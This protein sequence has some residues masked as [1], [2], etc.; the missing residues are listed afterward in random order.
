[1]TTKTTP[2]LEIDL[3][4]LTH[5][6]R[7]LCDQSHGAVGA[8]VKA[9]AYGLG[10]EPVAQT[11]CRAG[12][13]TFFVA[14]TREGVALRRVCPGAEIYVL[15][16]TVAADVEDL[17]AHELKPC[18]YS[19]E[20]YAVMAEAC[21]GGRCHVALHVETGINRLGLTE[22]EFHRVVE[23]PASTL[24]VDLIMSHLA[25]SDDPASEYN[26]Q[27]KNRFMAFREL[28]PNVK[29]SL[30][31]S[32]GVFLDQSFHFDLV[33]PGIALYGADPHYSLL[34]RPRLQPV[35]SLISEVAQT[36]IVEPGEGIGYGATVVVE[37]ATEIAVVMGGYADGINRLLGEP[38]QD[39]DFLVQVAGLPAPLLG[40]V[41]MDSCTLD[42]SST[43]MG[44]VKVGD[45]VEFFGANV[46]IEAFAE[47]IGTIPYEVLTHVGQRV[48][49][50]Y[51]NDP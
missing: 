39:D 48:A 23:Q 30:A 24:N 35:A 44:T 38:K 47:R 2:R 1:M 16:P 20:S 29:A 50:C 49:R 19:F 40:R 4:A 12:C 15:A 51:Y 41:S 3:G 21:R 10:L 22:S 32:G 18:L 11:L 7:T 33:R 17:L 42:L 28:L 27:Q 46:A 34:E 37:Q 26:R 9:D 25:C 13:D 8:V 31:N 14:F 43:Q 45:T 36:K 5:N 6:Y